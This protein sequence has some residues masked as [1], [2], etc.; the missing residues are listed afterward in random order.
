MRLYDRIMTS[1][2]VTASYYEDL[3]NAH[4]IVAD[5]VSALYMLGE[6][7]W[8]WSDFPN[9]A[10]PFSDIFFDARIPRGAKDPRSARLHR[11]GVE[12]FGILMVSDHLPDMPGWIAEIFVFNPPS[13]IQHDLVACKPHISFRLAI[14]PDGT[15]DLNS[16]TYPF[17]FNIPN[18][19]D[20]EMK[21]FHDSNEEDVNQLASLF[22]PLVN[23]ALLTICLMHC[24]NVELVE[25]IPDAK[26]AKRTLQRSGIAMHKYKVLNIDPMTKILRGQMAT[27]RGLQKSLHI[28]RGHFKDYRERGLFG[29]LR[30][31][32]WWP[33]RMRG[34]VDVGVVEKR[35]KIKLDEST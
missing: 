23:V 18:F 21:D 6:K 11:I 33:Q 7:E 10:P 27:G 9:I 19:T 26:L 20:K 16:E 5:N 8:G 35:Y 22:W 30:G 13:F 28:C 15:P 12:E 34:N 4:V 32:Y 3:R 1:Q 25:V 17:A 29:K 14:R 31:Q 2:D 24:K